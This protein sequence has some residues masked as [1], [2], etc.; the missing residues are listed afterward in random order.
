MTGC[1]CSWGAVIGVGAVGTL[2][3]VWL[4]RAS[5]Q[6]RRVAPR[7]AGGAPGRRPPTAL[8]CENAQL[9]QRVQTLEAQLRLVVGRGCLITVDLRKPQG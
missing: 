2:L 8:E 6:G 5:G 9:R 3:G 7:L 1:L 4:G